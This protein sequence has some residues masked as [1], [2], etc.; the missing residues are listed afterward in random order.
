MTRFFDK[1]L[2]LTDEKEQ[3]FLLKF[4]AFLKSWRG[5]SNILS[6]SVIQT[7][8]FD[9]KCDIARVYR[10]AYESHRPTSVGR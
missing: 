9:M 2:C 3:T 4:L 8:Q 6:N 10:V 7:W 5:R 1:I